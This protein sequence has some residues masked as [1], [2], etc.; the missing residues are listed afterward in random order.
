MDPIVDLVRTAMGYGVMMVL[1]GKAELIAKLQSQ[2]PAGSLAD[3]LTDNAEQFI[4]TRADLVEA[5]Q[6]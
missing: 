5:I 4:K 1:D 2:S 3:A 6:A